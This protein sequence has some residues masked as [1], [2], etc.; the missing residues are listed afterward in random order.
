[1]YVGLYNNNRK[2]DQRKKTNKIIVI[3]KSTY[4]EAQ[5]VF[6]LVRCPPDSNPPVIYF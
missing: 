6:F 1:M 3:I 4:L 5:P 2:I